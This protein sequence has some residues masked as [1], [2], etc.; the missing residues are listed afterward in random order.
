M[1]PERVPF[2]AGIDVDIPNNF[3]VE[4]T[5]PSTRKQV[6]D[7]VKASLRG[8]ARGVVISRKYSEMTLDNLAGGPV[9]RWQNSV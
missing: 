4:E 5:N 9:M 2:D 1:W 8:G 7:A 3:G 6:R